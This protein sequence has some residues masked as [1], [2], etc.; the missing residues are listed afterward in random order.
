MI[1]TFKVWPQAA[2]EPNQ[3][4]KHLVGIKGGALFFGHYDGNNGAY[5]FY[6]L[7]VVD[8]YGNLVRVE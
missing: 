5:G 1:H 4:G 2:A 3:I 7:A 6:A 8:D